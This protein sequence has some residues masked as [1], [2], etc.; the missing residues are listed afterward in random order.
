M[1]NSHP[2]D[3]A[4][5]GANISDILS[6]PDYVRVN[7]KD[8]SIEYVKEYKVDGDFVKV[9]VRVSSGGNFYARS[10]YI[11]NSNRVQSFIAKGTLKKI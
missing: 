10:L 1:Q 3:Y 8:N 7:Q 4:K 5:Y 6:S 9:A 11:L 2:A